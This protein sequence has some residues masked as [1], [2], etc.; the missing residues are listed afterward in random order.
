MIYM[1]GTSMTADLQLLF[2]GCTVAVHLT[3]LL[4]CDF[5]IQ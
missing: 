4:F 5:S 1:N 3:M 2:D